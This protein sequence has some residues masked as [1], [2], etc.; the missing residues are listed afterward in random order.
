MLGLF[1]LLLVALDPMEYMCTFCKLE[2][3]H[4]NPFWLAQDVLDME[5]NL[6]EL[7]STRLPLWAEGLTYFYCFIL[8]LVLRGCLALSKVSMCGEHI[9][10]KRMMPLSSPQ[11]CHSQ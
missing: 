5:A 10:Q 9:G 11:P 4:G 3:L 1:L 6:W 7:L 8:L 2:D